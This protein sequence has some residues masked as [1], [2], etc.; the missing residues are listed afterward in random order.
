MNHLIT[1]GIIVGLFG[2]VGLAYLLVVLTG[3]II[4]YALFAL[5]VIYY[6][7][8][9]FVSQSRKIHKYDQAGRL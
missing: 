1:M 3:P 9:C 7:T 2:V 4:T 8:Y 6:A 5:G